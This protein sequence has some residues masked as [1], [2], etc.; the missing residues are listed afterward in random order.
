ML[1]SRAQ[2]RR[3]AED[4]TVY[5]RERQSECQCNGV[6]A[7]GGQSR[8]AHRRHCRQNLP[9]RGR[10]HISAE[11][12]QQCQRAAFGEKLPDDARVPRADR[13]PHSHFAL[14]GQPARQQQIGDVGAPDQHE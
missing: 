14:P 2:R 12:A 8:N 6:P 7:R 1:P 9:C 4:D 10:Q 11:P 13:H 3:D 5:H